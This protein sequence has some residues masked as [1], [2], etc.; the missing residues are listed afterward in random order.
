MDL[1]TIDNSERE[2]N[3][4]NRSALSTLRSQDKRDQSFPGARVVIKPPQV[5]S[6]GQKDSGHHGPLAEHD[7]SY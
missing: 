3:V 6:V 5:V 4:L 7:L 1:K 2:G